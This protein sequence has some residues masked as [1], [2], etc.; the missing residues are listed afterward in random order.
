MKKKDNLVSV[1]VPVYNNEDRIQRC[2]YSILN[3]TY[4]NIELIVVNDGSTDESE[5]RILSINDNRIIYYYQDNSGPS[6][7]RNYGIEHAKGDYLMFVDSDDYIEKCMIET[8]VLT[9]INYC[10][11]IVSCNIYKKITENKYIEIKE[12]Y[13]HEQTWQEFYKNFVI[14]NGLCS[15]CN[16]IFKSNL[17]S[18]IKLYEDIRLGEDSTALLRILPSA[19]HIIHIN[20]PLYIYDLTNEGISRN[21]KKNVYEYMIAVK[22]VEDFYNINKIEIPIPNYLLRLK[23]CYYTLYFCSLSRAKKL[24]Y[25]DYYKLARD[26]YNDFNEIVKDKD[27]KKIALKFRIFTI[28]YN[29]F[30]ALFYRKGTFSE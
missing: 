25:W 13:I 18:K 7:A 11:E 14:Y 24:K 20:K 10:A 2:L 9:S 12:P 23:I 27:F 19:K 28:I 8:L 5:K 1:I 30:Y 4:K 3:Q 6:V 17:F 16:K 22:R 21:A 26:F 29:C 15:L